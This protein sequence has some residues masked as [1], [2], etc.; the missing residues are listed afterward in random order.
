MC[1][2]KNSQNNIKN[3]DNCNFTKG[4]DVK[5]KAGNATNMHNIRASCKAEELSKLKLK[6]EQLVRT[7]ITG[8]LITMSNVAFK[9]MED[10]MN[11]AVCW[12]LSCDRY[13]EDGPLEPRAF[14]WGLIVILIFVLSTGICFCYYIIWILF[15]SDETAINSNHHISQHNQCLKYSP[16]SPGG[17]LFSHQHMHDLYPEQSQAEHPYSLRHYYGD[18]IQIDTSSSTT[19]RNGQRTSTPLRRQG[20]NNLPY[21]ENNSNSNTAIAATS[22]ASLANTIDY[23]VNSL[24]DAAAKPIN[25]LQHSLDMHHSYV[26]ASQPSLH[27]SSSAHDIIENEVGQNEHYIYVTYPP[28]LK[29]RFFEKFE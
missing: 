19:H 24:S 6:C 18:Q 3:T 2:E 8:L 17:Q 9:E 22:T 25:S 23:K 28:D 10:E 29:K 26:G 27:A 5:I 4:S 16:D 20:Q 12:Y 1:Q 13:W 14:P 21:Q 11:K 15:D 7:C